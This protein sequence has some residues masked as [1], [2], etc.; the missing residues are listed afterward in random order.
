MIKKL[1]FIDKTLRELRGGELF[2]GTSG[3][4]DASQMGRAPILSDSNADEDIRVV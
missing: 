2:C 3:V 1:F 4:T